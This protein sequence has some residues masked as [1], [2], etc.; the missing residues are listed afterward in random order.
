[1]AYRRLLSLVLAAIAIALMLPVGSAWLAGA[2]G[3]LGPVGTFFQWLIGTWWYPWLAAY[4][5]QMKRHVDAVPY[6]LLGDIVRQA[7]QRAPDKVAFTCVMPNGMAGALTY[8]EVDRLSDAFAAYL[9]GELKLAPGSRVAIQAPN[10][11]AYPVVAFGVFKAGCTLVNINPLY[12]AEETAAVLADAEVSALVVIDMFAKRTE[13]KSSND[14]Y[15]NLE[16]NYL[17]QRLD[18]FE[19]IA[20]LTTNFGGSTEK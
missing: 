13:V 6:R 20:I 7:A 10:G 15:A 5:G 14:R 18:S 4:V 17:L 16:V 12:V 3:G 2:L 11:L 9:S 8:G 19:G 1:M